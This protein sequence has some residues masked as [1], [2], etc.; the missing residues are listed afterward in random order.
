MNDQLLLSTPVAFLI[1]NNFLLKSMN[2]RGSYHFNRVSPVQTATFLR[3]N[4][5]YIV[6]EVYQMNFNQLLNKKRI[7][8]V[9]KKLNAKDDWDKLSL[10]GISQEVGFKSR[11]TFIKAFKSNMGMT[12]SRYINSLS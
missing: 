7:E 1:G 4:L 2:E 5:S 9:I 10:S 11:T 3:N 6:N 12:P 8:V